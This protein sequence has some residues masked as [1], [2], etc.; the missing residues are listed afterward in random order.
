MAIQYHNPKQEYYDYLIGI[1]FDDDTP[2]DYRNVLEAMYN[3]DFQCY[4]SM[5]NN[6]VGDVISNLRKPFFGDDGMTLIGPVKVLEVLIA[7]AD[8]LAEH[9]ESDGMPDTRDLFRTMLENLGLM[10]YSDDVMTGPRSISARAKVTSII[11]DFVHR[12]YD[13]HGNGS[14]FP[15]VNPPFEA[16]L[17]RVDL[18][19]QSMWYLVEKYN[20]ED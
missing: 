14:I 17:S 10:A 19:Y 15:L 18:W 7:L 6:R 11:H 1:A 3:Y 9:I 4:V 13:S 5:D 12:K 8:R 20:F 16:D 2:N